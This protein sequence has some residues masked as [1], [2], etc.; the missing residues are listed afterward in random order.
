MSTYRE[1]PINRDLTAEDKIDLFRQMVRIRRFELEGLRCYTGGKMGG[2]FVPDIGQESIPV[3]VRSIMG[4]ED[5]T[6]CGWRGIG[7][8]IAAG[9]SMDACMAEHYG[10]ATGCCKGKGGAMSLFDPEHRFWGAYGLA[11]AH[12]PIAAGGGR[13]GA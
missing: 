12:T 5:H 13:R 9:M 7:H 11:A 3:G 1:H 4:P 8:A 6:I 10:K 2:F